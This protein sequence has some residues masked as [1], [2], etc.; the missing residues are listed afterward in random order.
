MTRLPALILALPL[1]L[2]G[3]LSAPAPEVETA[4]EAMATM[5][6]IEIAEIDTGAAT[7][8][9]TCLVP[10]MG[11]DAG[12][13]FAIAR[14]LNETGHEI[15]LIPAGSGGSFPLHRETGAATDHYALGTDVIDIA[16]D[17]AAQL[18]WG[19]ASWAGQCRAG[20]TAA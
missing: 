5:N 11:G 1:T 10:G 2:A 8:L 3:C 15:V 14:Q 16:P 18:L 20:G 13:H 17:G 19:G 7:A 4:P 6:A 9:W 12:W